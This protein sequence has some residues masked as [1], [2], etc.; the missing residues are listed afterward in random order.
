M[1]NQTR[2][3]SNEVVMGAAT[4][5]ETVP[6]APDG[7]NGCQTHESSLSPALAKSAEMDRTAQANKVR[8]NMEHLLVEEK[9]GA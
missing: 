1:I 4:T 3:V 2:S 8:T 7:Q 9:E 6:D 5:S